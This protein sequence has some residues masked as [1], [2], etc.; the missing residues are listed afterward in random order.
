MKL[1]ISFL[2]WSLLLSGN[3]VAQNRFDISNVYA[4]NPVFVNSPLIVDSANLIGEVFGDKHLLETVLL[5]KDSDFNINIVADSLGFISFQKANKSSELRFFSFNVNVNRYANLKISLTAPGMLE[6]YVD[7]KKESSKTTVEDSVHNA[8]TLEKEITVDPGTVEFK[9]KY[10]SRDE[11]VTVRE[12][13][14]FTIEASDS[15]T[16]VSEYGSNRLISINDII[17]GVKVRTESLS[18]DGRF[19]ILRYSAAMED[20]TSSSRYEL[21]SVGTGRR[22]SLDKQMSWTPLSS[23]L[24]GVVQRDG[25]NSLINIEPETMSET[26]VAENIPKGNFRVLHDERL[27]LY[28]E[29]ESYEERKGDLLILESPLDRQE[30]Y[31]DKYFIYL[32]DLSTGLKQRL[33]YGR[34]S[35]RVHDVSRDSRYILFSTGEECI[36]EPPFHK[37]SL[38]LFDRRSMTV[39]DTV[40]MDEKYA[41]SASFSPDA[42]KILILGAPDAFDGMGL[43]VPVDRMANSYDNQIFIMDRASKRIDPVSRKFNPSINSAVWYSDNEIYILAEDAD[44]ESAYKYSVDKKNFVKLNL[45]EEVIRSLHVAKNTAVYSG[46]SSSSPA[47]AYVCNLQTLE[48]TLVS[49]PSKSRFEKVVLG[50]TLDYNFTSSDGSTIRGRYYLPPTFDPSMKYPLIVYYY[51]GTSPTARTL[52][53]PY[54]MHVYASMDYVVYVVQP[55][56]ATGFGQEFSSRHVNAWGKRTADDIIEGV[57]NFVAD[58]P[59]VDKAKIGCIGASYGGF[60]TMYLQT[61]TDIFAAAVSHAGI[62]ALSS[63]WGEGYWGYAY[64]AVASANSYPWNNRSLYVEQSPLFN[65]DKIK[66]PLLL[67][68]GLDDTNVPPG[69]SFQMYT[70]LK[71]L[72]RP[73]EF[74]RVKGENHGIAAYARRREWNRSIYAWFEKWLKD[75]SAWW[76]SMYP[77]K[78]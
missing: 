41:S 1:K 46:L 18:P 20:G 51:G 69:E 27:L 19:A 55:S 25:N 63:Y 74:I 73:V 34:H 28:T 67:L 48:S 66:T 24:Y 50:Q 13:F 71:I 16:L 45:A 78:R 29:K 57:T 60:M 3:I 9:I 39:V 76:D 68:H 77:K 14:K 49:Y 30:G 21:Y 22:L 59:F 44:Y 38:Y 8:K 32:Y 4:T 10:L 5:V 15:L 17:E 52:D 11:S 53:H 40:W 31:F 6:L 65:A 37:T 42:S 75:D 36:T 26:L 70:A 2:I 35:T 54:P 43:D 56:G 72:G 23:K 7:N 58:H 61:V 47:K 62:S 64:S 12:F 33:T